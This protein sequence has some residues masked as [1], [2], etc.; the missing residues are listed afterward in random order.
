MEK[1]NVFSSITEEM[2]SK[3]T[4]LR[5]EKKTYKEI[6]QITGFSIYIIAKISRE[7]DLTN[8]RKFAPINKEVIAE[9][10]P[11]YLKLKSTRKV[12]KELSI[13]RDTVKKYLDLDIDNRPDK[14]LTEEE[15]KKGRVKSVIDWR[16]RTK[17][18]LV[19]YKGGKC[20]LCGYSKCFAALE[21]H[22]K[23]P[24]VKDFT[25]GG[26]SWSFERLKSEVD[27]CILVCSNCHQEIHS[28]LLD[29]NLNNNLIKIDEIKLKKEIEKSENCKCGKNKCK[30]ADVCVE[31]FRKEQYDKKPKLE[32]LLK[33]VEELGYCGTGRKYGV[34]DNAIR[35]WIKSI[36]K[37]EEK[38]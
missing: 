12:S 26:K 10:V 16:R 36:I 11:L 8:S 1:E 33:D 7:E 35:K 29:K 22:H 15:I 31:C 14:K 21:F 34:S 3:I 9:I 30:V 6:N 4:F 23:D 19:E 20:E 24:K 2:I 28:N 18:K 25:I 37:F 13:S 38:I 27:K 17:I 32:V 5:K